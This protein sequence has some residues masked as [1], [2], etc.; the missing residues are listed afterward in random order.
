MEARL[1]LLKEHW[2]G[3]TCILALECQEDDR[4]VKDCTHLQDK[5]SCS[6]I[7]SN[8][9][10]SRDILLLLLW[11]RD[12][13]FFCSVASIYLASSLLSTGT[14]ISRLSCLGRAAV[15]FTTLVL[16]HDRPLPIPH[17]LENLNLARSDRRLRY[18]HLLARESGLETTCRYHG[19]YYC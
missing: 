8:G 7:T 9:E 1:V 3:L 15:F 2:L 5:S 4:T 18:V 16:A 13:S 19:H 12:L 17:L 10:H 11:E 6:R 14:G